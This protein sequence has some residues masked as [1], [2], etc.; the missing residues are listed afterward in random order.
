MTVR[1]RYT[2]T[3]R[4]LCKV[5]ELVGSRNTWIKMG[6]ETEVERIQI[7]LYWYIGLLVGPPA[8]AFFPVGRR[9]PS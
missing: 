3:F 1:T 7:V 5:L 8:Y 6:N 4:L 9:K 2:P